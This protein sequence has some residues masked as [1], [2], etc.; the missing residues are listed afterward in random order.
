MFGET[1]RGEF[2]PEVL[3]ESLEFIHDGDVNSSE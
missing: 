1:E 3:P 2:T